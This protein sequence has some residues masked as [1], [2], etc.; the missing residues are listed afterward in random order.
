MIIA[1]RQNHHFLTHIWE[2]GLQGHLGHS[3]CSWKD[4]C[5]P[6][7]CPPE[8][9]QQKKVTEKM[10][11]LGKGSDVEKLEGAGRELEEETDAK[12]ALFIQW[13][14]NAAPPSLTINHPGRSGLRLTKGLGVVTE[15]PTPPFRVPG[16]SR[17]I[18]K[19]RLLTYTSNMRYHNCSVSAINT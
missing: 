9:K 11:R 16:S 2:G 18:P 19:P 12:Y 3:G 5:H 15:T 10:G 7:N 1:K 17:E 4:L 6:G 14:N 8:M 13:T